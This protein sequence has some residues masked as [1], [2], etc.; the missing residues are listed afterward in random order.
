[1][2]RHFWHFYRDTTRIPSHIR[3]ILVHQGAS[4]HHPIAPMIRHGTHR[5]QAPFTFP[6][7]ESVDAHAEHLGGLADADKP[8]VHGSITAATL[9][10]LVGD[11]HIFIVSRFNLH[12][13]WIPL[14]Y[15]QVHVCCREKRV[16]ILKAHIGPRNRT[17]Y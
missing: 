12:R 2:T 10:D 17:P 3:R 14:P 1:M 13:P 16:I 15:C 9:Y 5:N 4:V 6:L 8:F 7:S 11:L